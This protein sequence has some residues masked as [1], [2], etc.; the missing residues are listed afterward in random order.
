MDQRTVRMDSELAQK[1]K[2]KQDIEKSNQK[3]KYSEELMKMI[4]QRE[5]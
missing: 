4:S 2:I 3:K 5:Q 1:D